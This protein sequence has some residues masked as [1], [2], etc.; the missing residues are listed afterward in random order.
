M[1]SNISTSATV[2]KFADD[3]KLAN[4]VATDDDI[5]NMQDD[6]NH[7]QVWAET[8]QM[9]YNADKCAVMHFGHQKQHH[10]YHMGETEL[11]ETNEEKDL[12]VLISNTLKVSSQCA[13]EA[14]K[15]IRALG[16]I[17]RN[18]A[19]RSRDIILKLFKSLVRPHL[20]YAMQAWSPHMEKDKKVIEKVQARATKLIPSIQH[21]TYE[22]RLRRLNLTTMEKRRERGDII[23]TYRIMNQ[24]D[25]INP[26]TLFQKADYQGTRGH[27]QKLAKSRSRLDTRKY[28]YSQRVV[29]NWNKLPESAIQSPT[30]LCFKQELSKLGF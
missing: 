4:P 27:S 19:F 21:L 9:R 18:F 1:E 15:G 10:T 7:L 3:T 30:L 17:K 22:E 25:R 11:K 12:G 28:F 20:D 5:K 2:S 8:W 23:Q 24:I 26:D 13:T 16:L 14:K 6:I 29:E